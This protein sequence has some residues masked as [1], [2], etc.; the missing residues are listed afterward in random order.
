MAV[1]RGGLGK[2]LANLIPEAEKDNVSQIV[3]DGTTLMVSIDEVEPNPNQPRTNFDEDKLNELVD[4]ISQHGMVNPII[5]RPKNGYYEIVGGERRWRAAKLAGLSEV[6]ILVKDLTDREVDELALIDNLQREDLNPIEEAFAYKKLIDNYGL[7]QDEV[8]DR[9]SK[10]RAEVSNTLRLLNLD[11]KVQKMLVDGMISQSHARAVLGLP[12][13]EDQV[14]FAERIFDE[15]MS[16]RD[17]EKAV[18]KL[19]QE[20]KET[21]EKDDRLKQIKIV[22]AEVEEKLKSI[23]GT[24][25][26][27]NAKDENK[28]IIEIEYYSCDQMNELIEKLEA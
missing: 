10:S 27:I 3:G 23:L 7:K 26:R 5:V 8:A 13:G 1:K 25:V 14:K 20:K 18:K 24:K 16:V 11:E 4:S 19:T 2:G 15:K 28:G 12:Q 6:Q 22:Y 9:V 21:T 17:V